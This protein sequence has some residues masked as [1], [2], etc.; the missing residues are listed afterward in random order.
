MLGADE[1]D[2][3]L[4]DLKDLGE[5]VNVTIGANTVTGVYSETVQEFMGQDAA[6]IRGHTSKVLVKTGSL[7]GLV[8]GA[9]LVVGGVNYR[10]ADVQPFAR[11]AMVQ[12]ELRK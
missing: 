4:A 12:V 2:G 9:A 5:T 7:A 1:L 3:I 10:A 11:G 6:P 8:K